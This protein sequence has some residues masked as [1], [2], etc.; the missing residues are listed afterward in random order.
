MDASKASNRI[1]MALILLY[2]DINTL[3]PKNQF[4]NM[5]NFF[6]QRGP[7]NSGYKQVNYNQI[8]QQQ[9]SLQSGC[10]VFFQ[11]YIKKIL[12]E[13][14]LSAKFMKRESVRPVEMLN[15]ILNKDPYF[16]S[17]NIGLVNLTTDEILVD[18]KQF[19][20]AFQKVIENAI[21]YS[22]GSIN[23]SVQIEKTDNAI[24]ITCKDKGIGINQ[25][26]K[27]KVFQPFFRGL[28]SPKFSRGIGLGLTLSREILNH[29]GANIRLESEGR[30][31]GTS[32]FISFPIKKLP[33]V[34]LNQAYRP[35][36]ESQSLAY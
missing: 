16:K 10:D 33:K 36:E 17:S 31:S 34:N 6:G 28:D 29:H 14:E 25:F 3:C 11:R 4:K 27:K 19:K 18:T 20:F 24:L 21:F 35:S 22:E 12:E 2:F 26:E 7:F 1:L 30:G 32:V 23:A 9:A 5:D 13:G 8:T 15:E